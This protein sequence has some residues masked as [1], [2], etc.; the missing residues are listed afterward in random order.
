MNA[1]ASTWAFQTAFSSTAL[2]CKELGATM[3]AVVCT[4]RIQ[5][6]HVE[7]QKVSSKS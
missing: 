6:L 7:Q 3:Y 4:H 1:F 5:V 2:G